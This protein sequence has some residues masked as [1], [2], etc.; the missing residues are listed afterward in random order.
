MRWLAL[1][2]LGVLVAAIVAVVASRLVSQQIGLASEPISAGDALAPHVSHERRSHLKPRPSPDRESI[3]KPEPEPA[4]EP[5][6]T[7]PEAHPSPESSDDGHEGA[8][9]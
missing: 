5:Q 6:P 4:P 2:L 7:A 3:P 8:D 1:A 9:D